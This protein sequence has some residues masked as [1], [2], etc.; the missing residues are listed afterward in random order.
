[1]ESKLKKIN[2]RLL[3][4]SQRSSNNNTENND[5]NPSIYQQQQMVDKK[6]GN[7][8]QLKELEKQSQGW[9][10]NLRVFLVGTAA[11]MI[12]LC[13]IYKES[14]ARGPGSK[15]GGNFACWF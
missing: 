7:V 14:C 5:A 4:D 6:K 13:D 2:Q 1:M 8:I 10:T 3:S 12:R 11:E 15:A 9:G